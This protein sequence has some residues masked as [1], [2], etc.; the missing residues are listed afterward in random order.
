LR[1][2]LPNLGVIDLDLD[3]SATELATMT[4]AVSLR[5]RLAQVGGVAG[6]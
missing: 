3:G 4:S 2:G 6:R 1:A 5:A